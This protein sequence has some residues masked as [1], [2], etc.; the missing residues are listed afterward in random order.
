MKAQGL[1]F[2]SRMKPIVKKTSHGEFMLTLCVVDRIATHQTEAW[3]LEWIGPAAEAFHQAHAT[4]LVPGQPL[5]VE[6]DNIRNYAYATNG[7][8]FK[9]IVTNMT[10]EQCEVAA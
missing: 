4:R 3:R 9:G 6:L 7:H 10:I 1:V 8:E 2:V 5:K